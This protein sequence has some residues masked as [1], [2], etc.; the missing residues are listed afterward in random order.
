MHYAWR[1]RGK[2]NAQKEKMLFSNKLKDWLSCCVLLSSKK[3]LL[4]R[5]IRF[6]GADR[7]EN[8]QLKFKS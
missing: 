6:S 2:I 1:P 8:M 4:G 5:L 3:G 7:S